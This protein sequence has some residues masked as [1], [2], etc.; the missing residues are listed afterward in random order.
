MEDWQMDAERLAMLLARYA[1]PAYGATR[2]LREHV[3]SLGGLAC[4]TPAQDGHAE[5]LIARGTFRLGTGA[6]LMLGGVSQC[7]A[8]SAALWIGA[9]ERFQIVTGYALSEDGL[10]RQHSWALERL[11]RGGDRI[12]ETT[13]RRLAYF[14]VGLSEAESDDFALDNA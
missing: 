5:A 13:E 10:W 6:Y 4:L 1:D 7:H 11:A 3:L 2:P 12:V 9:P 8:N 14:G